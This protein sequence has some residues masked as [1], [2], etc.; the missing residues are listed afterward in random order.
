MEDRQQHAHHADHDDGAS[1]PAPQPSGGCTD[2][3]P[4]LTDIAVPHPACRGQIMFFGSMPVA[5]ESEI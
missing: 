1:G 4:V 2:W 3:A 5:P